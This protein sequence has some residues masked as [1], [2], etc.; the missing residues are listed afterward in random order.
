[1]TILDKYGE[2]LTIEKSNP[3]L[4][5]DFLKSWWQL[6]G[7]SD[8]ASKLLQ[9]PY[10]NHPWVYACASKIAGNLSRL[11]ILFTNP[12]TNEV[13][14]DDKLSLL[15]KRPNNLMNQTQFFEAILLNYLLPTTDSPGG[16]SFI[17]PTDAE[18]NPVDI[19]RGQLPDYLYPFND[20]L[21]KPER[22]NE[23]WT[24]RWL[25]EHK[26]QKI[27]F[28][29]D[30]VIRTRLF[31][32]YDWMRGLSPYSSLK[33]TV[34]SD[35]KAAGLSDKFFD[36]NA[37]VG[38]V[39]TTD[40]KL[41]KDQIQ[42][43][44]KQWADQ[45]EGWVNAGKTALLHSGLKYQS[46]SKDLAALE[47]MEQKKYS[48]E[49]IM[50]VYGV[51][52]TILGLTDTVNRA[53]AQVEK[54]LFWKDTLVPYKDLLWSDLN[55]QWLEIY[56]HSLRGNFD[57]SGVSELRGDQSQK[58]KDATFLI[59]QGVPAAEAYKT[60][61]LE[62]DTQ[63]MAWLDRPLVKGT[64]V[65][66]ETGE[67]IGAPTFGA[68]P[69][70]AAAAPAYDIKRE[71]ELRFWKD[72]VKA[73]LVTPEKK[74][75]KT[76]T[77]F[78]HKQRNRF[79]DLVDEWEEKNKS[80]KSIDVSKADFTLKDFFPKKKDE[81]KII[82]TDHDPIYEDGI[83]LQNRQM[84]A[85]LGEDVSIAPESPKGK[86]IRRKRYRYLRGVNSVTFN[87]MG[88]EIK[89]VF[90]ENEGE[91]VSKIAKELKKAERKA[92]NNRIASSAQTVARTETASL[93]NTTRNQLMED[94][95]I[96]KHQWVTAGDDEVRHTHELENL[97]TVKIGE[98]F[99]N[100]GLKYPLESGGDPE[101]VINCS[102]DGDSLVTTFGGKKPIREISVGDTVLTHN[103]RYRPVVRVRPTP[104][105]TG[106]AISLR[107]NIGKV[108][109]TGG[110]PF[111]TATGWNRAD[112]LES[113]DLIKIFFS[114]S[115][116]KQANFIVKNLSSFGQSFSINSVFVPEFIENGIKGNQFNPSVFESDIGHE[117]D[118]NGTCT[119]RSRLKSMNRHPVLSSLDIPVF[120]FIKN[121][122]SQFG[123]DVFEDIE[124]GI[125]NQNY[126]AGDIL[127]DHR[128]AETSVGI[129][130]TGDISQICRGKHILN[131]TSY[132][133]ITSL[134]TE[135]VERARVW[136][137][138][139]EEDES[140]VLNNLVSHNC[141]CV[142]VAVR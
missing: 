70:E 110:H 128:N 117:Q 113:G 123:L 124:I 3:D 25:F 23:S 81:D 28:L 139:V 46:E 96:E 97:V 57:L 91:S 44:G 27:P 1:M 26:G 21:V 136:N 2:P 120:G 79:L 108:R 84:S 38:G 86:T 4:D 35:V 127:F 107:T 16:Q 8:S 64:R 116:I 98:D 133:K 36:N 60:V 135:I 83:L 42:A 68:E 141:R 61:G 74:F 105:Y 125:C 142:T 87:T 52:K 10:A 140:Y 13:T 17:L 106:N 132:A 29:N 78:L 39:L 94:A 131:I 9:K 129:S 109:V 31:N 32:P 30:Q 50:A 14:S 100:T 102:L 99:P 56:D 122:H 103:G 5:P 114:A 47:F 34:T 93:A 137:F 90:K 54:E 80:V 55:T 58:I 77:S 92:F 73:T 126:K 18:G 71:K 59:N 33:I 104:Y 119:S 15:L 7:G 62:I 89:R 22:V 40:Q 76:F 37:S 111:Q 69:A 48:R 118:S 134:K 51:S 95:G 67:I 72:W 75:K 88:K 53:T 19:R 112:S 115:D 6:F 66:L 41:L 43:I 65:D 138:A 121:T 12:R 63:N 49:T 85:E 11:P 82:I 130:K 101:E 45:H 24:G 20:L